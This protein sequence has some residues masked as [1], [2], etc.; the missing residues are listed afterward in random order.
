ML[1][2]PFNPWQG[3]WQPRLRPLL[4]LFVSSQKTTYFF[5]STIG[6]V[7]DHCQGFTALLFIFFQKKVE[8]IS[9]QADSDG[10]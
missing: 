8:S 7:C 2:L 1:I 5:R 3:W 6:K 10:F 4:P 9:S